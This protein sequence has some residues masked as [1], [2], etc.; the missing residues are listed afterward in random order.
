MDEPVVVPVAVEK[1]E[2]KKFLCM[3]QGGNVRSVSLAFILKYQFKQDALACGWEGNTDETRKLLCDW[4][5][6]V[7]LMQ[8]EFAQYVPEEYKDK[9]RVVDVGPDNYGT[10]MHEGLLKFLFSVVSDWKARQF[11]I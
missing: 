1:P 7:I 9:I 2:A 3:C 6:V 8:A 4:A 10:P 11:R 5:D